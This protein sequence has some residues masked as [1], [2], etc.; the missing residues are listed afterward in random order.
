MFEFPHG[1][2]RIRIS[3]FDITPL[4]HANVGMAKNR[5]N[6]LVLNIEAM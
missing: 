6:Y 1:A 5:L 2:N 3:G 4:C